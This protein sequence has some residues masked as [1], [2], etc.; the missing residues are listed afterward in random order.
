M[1]IQI[2]DIIIFRQIFRQIF[3]HINYRQIIDKLCMYVEM[4]ILDNI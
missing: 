2:T 3:R 1:R 4:D